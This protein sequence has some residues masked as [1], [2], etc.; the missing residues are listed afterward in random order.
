MKKQVI[1]YFLIFFCYSIDAFAEHKIKILLINLN[2]EEQ[3]NISS[4]KLK[5]KLTTLDDTLEIIIIHYASVS[6]SMIDELK[7]DAIILSPQGTPWW[8]YPKQPLLEIMSVVRELKLPTLGICG[9]IQLLNMAYGGEVAPIKGDKKGKTYSGFP[10]EKG[11]M[12]IKIVGKSKLLQGIPLESYFYEAHRE[13]VKIVADELKIIARGQ[14]SPIQAVEHIIKPIYGVQFHP[15][16]YN[17]QYIQGQQVL[18]NFI[19]IIKEHS[20]NA[21]DSAK[22]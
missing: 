17:T 15:E 22:E 11:F 21:S 20:K 9:G 4:L 16:S 5:S 19:G 2:I 18:K 6:N 12:R 8:N 14:M 1:V 13:E 10:A 7:P 3:Q